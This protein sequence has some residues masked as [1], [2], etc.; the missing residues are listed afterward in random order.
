MWG[1]PRESCSVGSTYRNTFPVEKSL[2]AQIC[3]SFN[4]FCYQAAREKMLA[5][6]ER[7]LAD[8]D[9]TEAEIEYFMNKYK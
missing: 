4:L 8:G 1:L 2:N 9:L 3:V 7:L 6:K 5:E